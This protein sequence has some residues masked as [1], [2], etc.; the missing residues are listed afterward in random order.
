MFFLWFYC[1]MQ[2]ESPWFTQLIHRSIYL[3]GVLSNRLHTGPDT[4]LYLDRMPWKF[5]PCGLTQCLCSSVQPLA[6]TL[7]IILTSPSVSSGV[8]LLY[9]F[10]VISWHFCFI[11]YYPVGSDREVYLLEMGWLHKSGS[12]VHNILKTWCTSYSD[13]APG[14]LYN[15]FFFSECTTLFG[16]A[17]LSETCSLSSMGGDIIIDI[18][19]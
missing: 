17:Q 15:F 1:L 5:K 14:C 9:F 2:R 11:T 12:L 10:I 16:A 18:S 3:C 6:L 8:I 7:F 4:R 13:D 19:E